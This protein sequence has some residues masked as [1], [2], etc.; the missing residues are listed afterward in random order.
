MGWLKSA[1]VTLAV[2]LVE[3]IWSAMSISADFPRFLLLG[4][5]R[6]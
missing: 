1:G 6:I 4:E 5:L 2:S 3:G